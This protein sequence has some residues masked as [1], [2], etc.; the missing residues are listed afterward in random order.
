MLF[1]VVG[2]VGV[3]KAI[4]AA[5]VGE[6]TTRGQHDS[7]EGET[8]KIQGQVVANPFVVLSFRRSS[9]HKGVVDK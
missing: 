9:L 6:L 7:C 1:F 4:I 5:R 8:A 2:E 3:G